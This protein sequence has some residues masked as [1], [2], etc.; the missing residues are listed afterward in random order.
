M[1]PWLILVWGLVAIGTVLLAWSLF[2]DRAKG[3]KRCRKCW[4]AL[5]GIN[6]AEDGTTTCPSAARSIQSRSRCS[7]L[8]DDGDAYA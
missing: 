8:A 5:D 7:A 2:S 6:S 1:D 4:Y 3:R